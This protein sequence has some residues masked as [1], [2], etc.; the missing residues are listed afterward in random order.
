MF[1]LRSHP[2]FVLGYTESSLSPAWNFVVF[3]VRP[4]SGKRRGGILSSV[5]RDMRAYVKRRIYHGSCFSFDIA[6]FINST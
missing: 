2:T 5:D 4:S 1:L 6:T 3:A